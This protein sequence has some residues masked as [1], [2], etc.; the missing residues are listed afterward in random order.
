MGKPTQILAVTPFKPTPWFDRLI[1]A[2]GDFLCREGEGCLGD[3]LE[4]IL[5]YILA[6]HS[7]R[8]RDC[9]GSL[10]SHALEAFKKTLSH[11]FVGE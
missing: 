3:C 1:E 8:C 7:K 6:H 9:G 11:Q 4:P 2:V 10:G 5:L